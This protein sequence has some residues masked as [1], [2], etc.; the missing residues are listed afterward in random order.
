LRYAVIIQNIQTDLGL[1]RSAFPTLGL[2]G[3]CVFAYSESK[4]MELVDLDTEL[5]LKEWKKKKRA[6]IQEIV[7][8]SML[9]EQEKEWMEEYALQSLPGQTYDN[10]NGY[11]ERV[12]MP[13]LFDMR[14]DYHY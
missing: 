3:D 7:E 11:V 12:V 8:S 9:S 2:E 5:F 6:H 1:Q 10:A 14:R 4:H 13:N